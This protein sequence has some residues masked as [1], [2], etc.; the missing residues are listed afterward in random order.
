MI[1]ITYKNIKTIKTQRKKKK[2]G[3][4]MK[5]NRGLDKRDRIGRIEMK[6]RVVGR[7]IKEKY[8][9]VDPVDSIDDTIY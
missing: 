2:E 8:R 1:H 6:R 3:R 4:K 5:N 9:T 7:D